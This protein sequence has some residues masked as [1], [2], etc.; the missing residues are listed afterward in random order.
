MQPADIVDNSALKIV[1]LN[2]K[3]HHQSAERRD[4]RLPTEKISDGKE[5]GRGQNNLIQYH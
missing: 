1:H 2:R 5:A 4:E 3:R